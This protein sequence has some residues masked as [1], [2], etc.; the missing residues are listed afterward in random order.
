MA[1]TGVENVEVPACG[2]PSPA[3]VASAERLVCPLRAALGGSK[4]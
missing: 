3:A 1:D 4:E 2:T